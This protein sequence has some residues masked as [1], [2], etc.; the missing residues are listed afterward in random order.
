MNLKTLFISHLNML[1]VYHFV[2]GLAAYKN[3]QKVK[4]NLS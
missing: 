1:K 2:E 4:E 3:I